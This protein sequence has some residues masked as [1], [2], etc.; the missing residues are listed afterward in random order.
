MTITIFLWTIILL[1]SFHVAGHI[2]NIVACV[3]NWSSGTIEDMNRYSNFYHKGNNTHYFAPVIFSSIIACF[4]ALILVWNINTITR[5]L[6]LTDL[7][8]SIGVLI[9]VFTLFRPMNTYFGSKQYETVKLKSMVNRWNILNYV[10]LAIILSGLII[11][12]YALYSFT[13]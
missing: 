7:I 5:N 8:I 4:I 3:R 2:H 13:N 11:S 12:I 10:R 6:V 9:S 1:F